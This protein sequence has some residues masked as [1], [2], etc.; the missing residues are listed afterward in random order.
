MVWVRRS[1]QAFFFTLFLY[2]F[3]QTEYHPINVTGGSTTFFFEVDPLILVSTWMANHQ[4]P[5]AL[6]FS[7][8]TLLITL[9]AGRWFCGW[10]CPF[11]T[12]HN[13][14]TALR[15]ERFKI[16]TQQE[17]Y[18]KWQKSKYYLLVGFILTA[19]LGANVIGW[20]DPFSFFYRSLT[21]AVF[22]VVHYGIKGFFG[23]IYTVDPE[24]GGFHLTSLTEP[25][26]EPL[27]QYLL[28][29]QQ[30]YYSGGF[31]LGVFFLL[32][33]ALNLIRNRFWCRYICPLGALLGLTGKNPMMRLTTD[34]QACTNCRV[35]LLDCQGAANPHGEQ[36]WKPS[37][38]FFCYNC[39]SVC[40]TQAIR[41]R[42]DHPK[43]KDQ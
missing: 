12:L 23:W 3:I 11:G 20:L 38:C 42:W 30:P 34:R 32:A 17:E 16:R 43:E 33:V 8:I 4:V 35:C 10:F 26:Y 28:L 31:L 29:P 9:L 13:L 2:L 14:F 15:Q 19:L 21:T 36:S 24:V 27:R 22:P 1:V 7:L 39:S 40:P 6:L 5:E 41:I 37:E 25:I 18:S